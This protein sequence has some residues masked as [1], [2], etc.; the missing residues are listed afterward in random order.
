MSIH[1]RLSAQYGF[2]W[3]LA[4]AIVLLGTSKIE[5]ELVC[6]ILYT[7]NLLFNIF[8]G[9]AG[10]FIFFA[11][12][13][14]KRIWHLYKA[15]FGSQ[16]NNRPRQSSVFQISRSRMASSGSETISPPESPFPMTA[17]DNNNNFPMQITASSGTRY[18]IEEEEEMEGGV[19][20]NECTHSHSDSGIYS[21]V[22]EA[23]HDDI[24][25]STSREY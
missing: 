11:F 3:L 8:N 2:A 14:N 7:L 6:Y 15:R 12:I 4:I 16:K 17:E 25:R 10:L 23:H 13:F 19:L 18:F 1:C 20:V 24:S 21:Q 9:L 5:T 22:G